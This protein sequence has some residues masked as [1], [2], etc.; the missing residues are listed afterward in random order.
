MNQNCMLVTHCE[1]MVALADIQSNKNKLSHGHIDHVHTH[2]KYSAIM[3]GSK[4]CTKATLLKLLVCLFFS[5]TLEVEE[6]YNQT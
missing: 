6:Y 2:S 5:S 3:T 1:N 4:L